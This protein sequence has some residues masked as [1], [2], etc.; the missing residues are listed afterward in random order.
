MASYP[1]TLDYLFSLHRFGIK[2]G[3]EVIAD[4]LRRL[5]N[6]QYRFAT[7]HVGGTNGKGSSAAMAASILMAAGYRVGLYT[8]PHLVDFRE[9]IQVQGAM[10]SPEQV[11]DLTDRIRGVTDP[12]GS[13]TFFECTTAMAFQ[14]FADQAVDIGVVEVGMGGRFDA[15]NVLR[16]L[17]VLIST[18]AMDH[19]MYLG[20]TLEAIAAE[21]AGILKPHTVAVL[22]AL[23]AEA[24]RVIRQIGDSLS[25][26][27]SQYGVDFR[28]TQEANGEFGYDG[29]LWHWQ[30][31]RT[32]LLGQHQVS[33]AGNVLALLEAATPRQF[34]VTESAVRAG[35]QQVRWP[36]RLE[37]VGH[38]PLIVMDGAHNP[39]AAMVL[40]D[41]LQ[42]QLH[43]AT[44]RKLIMVIGMMK[45]KHHA[46]FLRLFHQ[47]TDC[48][49]LTQPHMDRAAS[50]DMLAAALELDARPP[51]LIADPKEAL[52]RA[53]VLARPT[54]VICVTGSLF[55]V[56][57]IAG[58]C[59]SSGFP[60]VQV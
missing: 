4:L 52:E 37:V 51:L 30:G 15:T 27:M 18:V 45:D 3:L 13:L 17:G 7:L 25:A 44:D 29:P 33:N 12:Q 40:F 31:L 57:E 58:Y 11:C 36:G 5:G 10:I 14:H 26:P 22:G 32:N 35:L 42:S 21:K 47:M 6:P 50:P 39:S 23:P 60:A 41:F 19:E 43:D 34:Q 55:L 54:D 59:S 28:V 16:P 9:R 48:L 49:I 46:G 24:S 8:S 56:G 20:S 2:L 1:H 53:K 38:D